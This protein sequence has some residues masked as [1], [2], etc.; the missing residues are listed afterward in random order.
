MAQARSGLWPQE[1]LLGT[2]TGT[3]KL[4]D[5]VPKGGKSVTQEFVS[6]FHLHIF[7]PSNSFV[8]GLTESCFSHR[9]RPI[10]TSRGMWD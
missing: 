5:A 10:E 7:K 1:K 3:A 4:I 2:V 6:F 8:R 9:T